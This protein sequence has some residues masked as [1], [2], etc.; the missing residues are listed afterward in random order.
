MKEQ[1]RLKD[2]EAMKFLEMKDA[3]GEDYLR[4]YNTYMAMWNGLD[5]VSIETLKSI[6]SRKTSS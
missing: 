5:P 3:C 6:Q 1:Q 4:A 2:W